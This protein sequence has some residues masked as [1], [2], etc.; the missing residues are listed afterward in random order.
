MC[1]GVL[2]HSAPVRM[3][4]MKIL[5]TILNKFGKNN[6]RRLPALS[7]VLL[8]ALNI[9]A[10]ALPSGSFGSV[11]AEE[12][13]ARPC[14]IAAQVRSGSALR[15][16]LTLKSEPVIQDY[17][18]PQKSVNDLSFWVAADG[19]LFDWNFDPNVTMTYADGTF[20]LTVYSKADS[21]IQILPKSDVEITALSIVQSGDANADCVS[22]LT[23]SGISTLA[24]LDVSDVKSLKA[25]TLSNLPALTQVDASSCSLSTLKI[26]DCPKTGSLDVSNNRL[27]Y[28]SLPVPS[29][30]YTTYNYGSQSD[31]DISACVGIGE[32][33]DLSRCGTATYTWYFSDDDSPVTAGLTS[34]GKLGV[35][36]VGNELNG[37]TIYCVI[38]SGSYPQL[39]KVKTT[40]VHIVEN[41]QFVYSDCNT[42]VLKFTLSG[43]DAQAAVYNDGTDISALL[44]KA[45]IG[46]DT[47]YTL[48]LSATDTSYSGNVYVASDSPITVISLKGKNVDSV[49]T[50]RCT[51]LKSVEISGTPISEID[52]SA[53][54]VLKSAVLTDNN[55]RSFKLPAALEV[56]NISGN[57][58]ISS[59]ISL[60]TCKSTLN[61]LC[62]DNCSLKV[63]DLTDFNSLVHLSAA[64]NEIARIT[65]PENMYKYIDISDNRLTFETLPSYPLGI[66][67]GEFVYSY[68]SQAALTVDDSYN[69]GN[70]VDI[71]S[72]MKSSAD[73]DTL[74]AYLRSGSDYAVSSSDGRFVIPSE[75]AGKKIYFTLE[76][77]SFNK[78]TMRSDSVDVAASQPTVVTVGAAVR[79][80]K[81][82]NVS[83]S[84]KSSAPVLVDWGDGVRR[85][86][87]PS[88]GDYNNPVAISG[89][90]AETNDAAVIYIYT[91]GDI[92]EA[93]FN[94]LSN[95]DTVCVTAVNFSHWSALKN[96]DLSGNNLSALSISSN[97]DLESLNV[98]DNSFTFASLPDFDGESYTYAPQKNFSLGKTVNVDG[99]VDLSA[100]GADSYTWY[101]AATN[102]E[103]TPKTASNG[104][105]TFG[106]EYANM[107]LY[108]KMQNKDYW[109]LTIT[110]D[111]ITVKAANNSFSSAT[112][113][114]KTALTSGTKAKLLF[115]CDDAVYVDWGDSALVSAVSDDDRLIAEGKLAGDTVKIY[116]AGNLTLLS[117]TDMGITEAELSSAIALE[118]LDLS[119]NKLESIDVSKNNALTALDLSDNA[120]IFPKLPAVSD[121]FES[122]I[123]SPQALFT[124]PQLKG[125]GAS[126]SALTALTTDNAKM[127]YAWYAKN[128]AGDDELLVQGTDK[129]YVSLGNGKFSFNSGVAGKTV[130]CIVSNSQYPDLGIKTTDMQ[131]LAGG[132]ISLSDS[133]GMVKNMTIAEGSTCKTTSG[134]IIPAGDLNGSAS[135]ENAVLTFMSKNFTNT[136]DITS[137]KLLTMVKSLLSTFNASDNCHN[138][139]DFSFVD[140]TGT[141]VADFDG[142]VAITLNYPSA[143]ASKY[144][145]Y[146]FY[147]F[148]YITS[149]SKK[150]TMEQIPVSADSAG[151]TFTATSFSPYVL[152]YQADPEKDSE[153]NQN[154]G[155]NGTSNTPSTGDNSEHS[156]KVA[157]VILIIS[158]AVMVATAVVIVSK[159]HERC[160]KS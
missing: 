112:V 30:D 92:T 71:S 73:N 43:S 106:S 124:I 74:T 145:E 119:G 150:G 54:A 103:V 58:N 123:Y 86:Y 53:N 152:V 117:A 67:D 48:D 55:L 84:L 128:T 89:T 121:S 135:A 31:M 6:A 160:R 10:S 59:L 49:N 139:Y 13:L 9:L 37:R 94:R 23:V 80:E 62:I 137:D 76:S 7:L 75:L 147:I 156:T 78:L 129:D 136:S 91:A 32:E 125:T 45:V 68:D 126:M 108:C 16:R 131:I 157:T 95:S 52:L 127:G 18:N 36:T 41:L 102:E 146:D 100:V 104:V 154:G 101:N 77:S 130:Y 81:A 27:G 66:T 38:E 141:P 83:F 96:L 57:K 85:E 138:I 109:L 116:T 51:A 8:F 14:V 46:N 148:H 90:A 1:I 140:S 2:F 153:K 97:T 21:V 113:T 114:L 35:V 12:N 39:P 47:E 82:G 98:S 4:S 120:F 3:V 133:T 15:L 65:L 26:V 33:I 88:D 69:V 107:S 142:S 79:F 40:P 149:G 63:L 111:S 93:N 143:V 50:E 42:S 70:T 64:H 72:Q 28:D 44:T 144:S 60:D 19:R 25:L 20:D 134:A 22:S 158:L 11:H 61:T 5:K 122:Y 99:K 34:E 24:A 17:P 115:V 29:A 118:T 132:G 56:L 159:K 151:L 110:T 105:F 87:I 155:S